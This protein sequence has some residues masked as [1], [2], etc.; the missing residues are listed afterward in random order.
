MGCRGPVRTTGPLSADPPPPPPPAAD[1]HPPRR[2]RSA[3]RAPAVVERMQLGDDAAGRV[4]IFS[5]EEAAPSAA[6]PPPVA[7]GAD[8]L[9]TLR[10]RVG[11]ALDSPQAP[12]V[13][14][15]LLVVVLALGLLLS[16]H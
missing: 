12:I 2:R 3:L 5:V 8:R 15:V 4:S 6:Q 10:Q 16:R 11:E 13:L 7:G 9:Q 14:A 1:Q